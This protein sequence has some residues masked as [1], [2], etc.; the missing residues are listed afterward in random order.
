ME[1][2]VVYDK[3]FLGGSKYNNYGI[4]SVGMSSVVDALCNIRDYCFSNNRRYFSRDRMVKPYEEI[5]FMCD[6]Q[7]F[8]AI[9]FL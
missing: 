2:G 3:G 6:T 9:L 5:S 8:I 7:L 4:L 1:N